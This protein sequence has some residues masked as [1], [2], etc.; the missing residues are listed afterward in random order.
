VAN[1]RYYIF[2]KVVLAL[3]ANRLIQAGFL[4]KS[5]LWT[6]YLSI[7][8]K[9]QNSVFAIERNTENGMIVKIGPRCFRPSV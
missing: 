2:E 6:A 1:I 7:Q 8:F 4:Y 9:N 3:V 5:I